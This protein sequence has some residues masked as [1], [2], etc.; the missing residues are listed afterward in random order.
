M[1][2]TVQNFVLTHIDELE[3]TTLIA[4]GAT[5]D[6]RRRFDVRRTLGITSFGIN[7]FVA[8]SGGRVIGEHDE[9]PLGV[10]GQEELY[11]VLRGAATF[12]IDGEIVE[13]P[14]GAM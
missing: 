4:P 11:L 10:A 5:D 13:A 8:P 6:G 3:P 7:A 2:T 12:E 1:S 14:T 9:T